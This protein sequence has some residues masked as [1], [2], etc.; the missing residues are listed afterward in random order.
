MSRTCTALAAAALPVVV[1]LSLAGCA[2]PAAEAPV[3]EADCDADA[4]TETAH[5]LLDESDL[6][7]DSVDRLDCSDGWSVI[8]VTSSGD[9]APTEAT[10]FVFRETEFSWVLKA[11]EI[12]C[13]DG[14]ESLPA[15]LRTGVC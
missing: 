5:H 3:L 10:T 8:T 14:D 7:L 12:V 4:I 6:I 9:G 11:P 1:L 15:V 2:S 13:G